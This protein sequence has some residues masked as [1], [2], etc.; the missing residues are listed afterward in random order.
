MQFRFNYKTLHC[1]GILNIITRNS[2]SFQNVN[3]YRQTII[4]I[5]YS[6]LNFFD[7]FWQTGG[8]GVAYRPVT[9][10]FL[11]LAHF[12][13]ILFYFLAIC[14]RIQLFLFDFLI[15]GSLSSGKTVLFQWIFIKMKIFL[16]FFVIIYFGKVNLDI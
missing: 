16:P 7:K 8:V 11:H 6:V 4:I 15:A 13:Y 3:L 5:S 1:I 9:P 14:C 12:N 2:V 10:T